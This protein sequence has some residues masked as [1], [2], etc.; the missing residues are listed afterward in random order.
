MTPVN[1]Q[2]EMLRQ[3]CVFSR[4]FMMLIIVLGVGHSQLDLLEYHVSSIH[5]PIQLHTKV[6]HRYTRRSRPHSETLNTSEY[7]IAGSASRVRLKCRQVLI[8]LT[9]R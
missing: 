3:L 2:E 9:P 1:R 4:D 7:Y 8:S 5:H 6:L